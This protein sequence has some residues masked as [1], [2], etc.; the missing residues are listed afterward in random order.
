MAATRVSVA[1]D[2]FTNAIQGVLRDMVEVDQNYVGMVVGIVDA[3]GCRVI[4]QGRLD[5][6]GPPVNGDTLFEVASMDEQLT[7]LL[8][9][10]MVERGEVNLDDPVAKYLPSSVTMPTRNGRQITLLDLATHRSGLPATSDNDQPQQYPGNARAQYT[11]AQL[12]DFLSSYKLSRDPGAQYDENSLMGVNLLGYALALRAGTNLEALVANR[13]CQ[14]LGMD[15]TRFE[16]TPEWKARFATGHNAFGDT[17]PSS[18]F[19]TFRGAGWLHST[20]NDLLKFVSANLG[21]TPSS[22]APAMKKADAFRFKNGQATMGLGW[23]IEPASHGVGDILSHCATTGGFEC[24]VSLDIAGRRG[25]VVLANSS[26]NGRVGSLGFSLLRSEWRSEKRMS[27][28]TVNDQALD[29]CVGQYQPGAGDVINIRRIGNRLQWQR[30]GQLSDELM[31]L[32]E[33]RFFTRLSG[34]TERF[35]FNRMTSFF[36]WGWRKIVDMRYGRG[37]TSAGKISDQPQPRPERPP[38]RLAIKLDPNTYDAYVGDYE[39]PA[40]VARQ[41]GWGTLMVKQ[42]GD[43]LIAGAAPSGDLVELMPESEADFFFTTPRGRIVFK[44]NRAGEVTGLT[45]YVDSDRKL[46]NGQ[47]AKKR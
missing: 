36:P 22:L 28:V 43:V 15:S 21:L 33:T 4:S 31:P 25:V 26:D 39:F 10:D 45:L 6:D 46:E 13:I 9:Q 19:P 38:A 34:G 27:P 5:Q 1:A 40:D 37:Y 35:M 17:V 32:S 16:L 47:F 42:A 29:A 20:A 12:Y 41:L 11:P 24:F 7:D 2:D 3:H 14:P 30:A 18:S 23:F 44:T 8:L